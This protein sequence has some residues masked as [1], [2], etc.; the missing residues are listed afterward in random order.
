MCT[1]IVIK[2]PTTNKQNSL[3]NKSISL[4]LMVLLFPTQ[5]CVLIQL[6]L[7]NYTVGDGTDTQVGCNQIIQKLI[8]WIDKK[9]YWSNL[10]VN[11]AQRRFLTS[12]LVRFRFVTEPTAIGHISNY[13]G[14]KSI[15]FPKITIPL[16]LS[17][18]FYIILEKLMVA[19][20][21]Q[22]SFVVCHLLY[23]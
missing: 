13:P 23:C 1:W 21:M 22:R 7:D 3:E 10:K 20:H 5:H 2:T 18:N 12:S 15:L 9:K 19:L 8:S 11:F 14:P 16:P 4:S 6:K 17:R